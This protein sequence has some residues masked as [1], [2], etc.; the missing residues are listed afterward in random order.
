MDLVKGLG[1]HVHKFMNREVT[2]LGL[3]IIHS[4]TLIDLVSSYFV[5]HSL[6]VDD[7]KTAIKL[8]LEKAL[9][10]SS[11]LCTCYHV[12]VCVHCQWILSYIYFLLLDTG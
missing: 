5:F 1:L 12:C 11:Y 7:E 2:Y 3:H 4:V 10:V 6:H 9:T 8:P